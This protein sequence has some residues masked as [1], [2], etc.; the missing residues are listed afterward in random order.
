MGIR[1]K[2][3][4]I[5][6]LELKP[7]E[8]SKFMLL[9]FY[10]FFL[11]LFIAFYFVP[12]NSVFIQHFGS[13]FLPFAY[14][15]AGLVGYLST[16][17]YSSLQKKADSR[18]LFLGAML[19]MLLIT[20]IG[21]LG[22]SRIDE[23]WLSFFVF[24]WAWPFI[25]LVGII[26]GGLA[27]RLLNLRQVKRLFGLINMGGVIASII[28]Y[29]AIPIL[30]PF[31][32]H[33]YDLLYVGLAGILISGVLIFIIY[34]QFPEKVKDTEQEVETEKTSF[35]S[36]FKY[37]YYRL[38]FIAATLSMT[39]IYFADFSFLASI[40][41]QK[42]LF[43]TPEE[44]SNFIA[45][46]FGLLKIGELVMSY[47]SSR[48]LSKYGV[49][50]GLTILPLTSTVLIIIAGAAGLLSGA[51]SILFFA[52][53]VANKIFERVLRRSL[54]DPSFNI[55]YQPLP[56]EQKLAIQTK[57]GVIMQLAIGIAGVFLLTI[58]TVLSINNG[59]NLRYFPLL[60]IPVLIAWSIVAFSL[61]NAYR[62]KIR[63]ILADKNRKKEKDVEEEI[64]GT[65]V[66]IKKLKDKDIK[67]SERVVSFLSET[68]PRALELY[69]VNLLSSDNE[70]VI[71]SI[72]RT[73]D[74][75]Y[76]QEYK[77]A[78]K[79]IYDR[80]D[81][82]IIKDLASNALHYLE[83]GV[84]A[85]LTPEQI[86]ELSGSTLYE[87]K[88]TLL[89][90]LTLN[91][92]P[93]DEN[94]LSELLK[95][96][97]K[98]IRRSAIKLAGKRN[99][100]VLRSQLAEL[101]RNPEFSHLISSILIDF[102][103]KVVTDLEVF[104]KKDTPPSILMKIIEIYAKIGTPTTKSLM[105]EHLNYPDK[106][107]QLSIIRALYYI[108]FQVNVKERVIIKKKLEEVVENILWVFVSINDLE[109]KKNTLK[110]I[111]ALDLEREANFEILFMLLS[112]IYQ[113]ATIDL[114]RTNI[115]GENTIF[116][117]EIIENFI[118]QDIKTLIIPLF[119]KI[120]VT[121][122]V[123]KLQSYFPQ[124]KM[125]FVDRLKDIITR[126]YNKVDLWTVAKAIEL[127]G[128]LFRKKASDDVQ[129]D[130]TEHRIK[131]DIWTRE[132]IME[133]LMQI[134]KSEMPDEVFACL[135]HPDE[136]VYSTAAKVIYDENP[137]R[138]ITYLQELPPHKQE[139]IEIL[140]DINDTKNLLIERVKLIKRVP[141]FFSVP[142][143]VLVKLVKLLRAR[144]VRRNTDVH[145]VDE[146]K[147]E[148]IFIVLKGPLSFQ[149]TEHDEEIL[150]DKNDIIVR[151]INVDQNTEKVSSK[152]DSQIL[153]G[154][155][156]E[157]FNLL[158]DE[159]D[160]IK[161]M[162]MT[163]KKTSMDLSGD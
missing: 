156:Y 21:R 82:P 140:G 92:I 11:G 34:Q 67:V 69:G 122:R 148:K 125:K 131:I 132:N 104:F 74:P 38:I 48:I 5:K 62:E 22:L 120:S 64:Y 49:K 115:I 159:I 39:V 55:L 16:L 108:G 14:I 130:E 3:F 73:I 40:K 105:V 4:I 154:N 76:R 83:Y 97:N 57:V 139:L 128:K 31:V 70:I 110:L 142:E 78:I 7:E 135:Y 68:N 100:P 46:V 80:F 45:I 87:D 106:D 91:K 20:L 9:F 136:L 89:K 109:A 153:V 63:Q 28:G 79:K 51:E 124:Q 44:V 94:I 84:I 152:R 65:D 147:E 161:P 155:R 90:Y 59:F 151:G 123:K 71:K 88:L 8:F 19:F 158:I 56:D 1:V 50:L 98:V 86:R 85:T 53:I 60:Y 17:I 12:A 54:D 33:S 29:L 95:D 102:G 157:F 6:T 47:F 149:K 119:D 99:S 121:Q 133:L 43:T 127:L 146:N 143:N 117:L 162:F 37:K 112:F 129:S 75:T 114:I 116:A 163:G 35:R 144:K 77:P 66:L 41:A 25:S 113:Q 111:Q 126:D 15:A 24:V 18:G 107:V 26:T 93:K 81:E 103:E 141:M 23:K 58:H 160:I 61:Y 2:A 52:L 72:L 32:G 27:I 96:E 13:E 101:L 145:F 134:R 30:V 138:C 137:Q 118:S 10:S 42:K 150:F 36:L